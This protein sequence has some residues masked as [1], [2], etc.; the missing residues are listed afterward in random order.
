MFST[1]FSQISVST[2][3]T[4]F[5]FSNHTIDFFLALKKKMLTC[6]FP[7]SYND[8]KAHCVHTHN[9]SMLSWQNMTK[10]KIITGLLLVIVET[11]NFAITSVKLEWKTKWCKLVPYLVLRRMLPVHRPMSTFME[12]GGFSALPQQLWAAQTKL[13][14]QAGSVSHSL[15]WLLTLL[16]HN[17]LY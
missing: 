16:I 6:A 1:F 9:H 4:L 11:K 3:I 10:T 15:P 14:C 12:S 2:C 17:S 13:L 5:S 7:L 8:D